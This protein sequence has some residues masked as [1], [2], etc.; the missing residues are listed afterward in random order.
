M[1]EFFRVLAIR[2]SQAIGSLWAL[3]AILAVTI[4]TGAYYDFSNEWKN[5]VMFYTSI[6]TL[7]VLVFLQRS[8]NHGD[9]ATSLKLDELVKSSERARDEVVFAENKTDVAIEELRK[10]VIDEGIEEQE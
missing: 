5:S 7:L 1:H 3:V 6:I 4:S 2:V 8:Q 9:K 10:G